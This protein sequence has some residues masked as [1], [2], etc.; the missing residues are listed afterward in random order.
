LMPHVRF[1]DWNDNKVVK[2]VE[3]IQKKLTVN[4]LVQRYLAPDGLSG[5]EG[6]FLICTFW[7]VDCLAHMDKLEEAKK[8]FERLLQFGK[9]PLSLF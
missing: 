6:A 8:L 4:G 2:T 1:L 7:L 5:D 3:L 9:P